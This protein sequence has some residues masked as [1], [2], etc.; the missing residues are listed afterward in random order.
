MEIGKGHMMPSTDSKTHTI[1]VCHKCRE[2]LV[3]TE[4]EKR[5][6]GCAKCGGTKFSKSKRDY[7][8][9]SLKWGTYGINGDEP[10]KYVE[11]KDCDTNH[12]RNIIKTQ[13]TLSP[14]Y[15]DTILEILLKREIKMVRKI[16]IKDLPLHINDE[17]VSEGAKDFI[18][19]RL[20]L[21]V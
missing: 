11:L 9:P 16:P 15:K 7:I 2:E 13:D 6:I 19:K 14:R 3:V 21:G 5:S 10:L 12:L 20:M 17:W 8:D 1:R 4:G 18:K